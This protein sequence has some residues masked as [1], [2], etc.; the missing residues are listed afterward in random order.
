MNNDTISIVVTAALIIIAVSL[1][2]AVMVIRSLVSTYATQAQ[3]AALTN[4]VEQGVLAA[5]QLGLRGPAAKGYVT[6]SVMMM[7]EE[8]GLSIPRQ[9]V[10]LLVEAT[11]K[12]LFN[13]DK[14]KTGDSS[15]PV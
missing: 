11:V 7:A 15:S 3:Q 8:M 5:E 12:E 6:D 4:L 9:Y 1:P 2:I 10:E 14:K 13:L